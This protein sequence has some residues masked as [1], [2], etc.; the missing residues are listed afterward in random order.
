MAPTLH[1]VHAA[2]ERRSG[3]RWFGIRQLAHHQMHQ[4]KHTAGQRGYGQQLNHAHQW[5][6]N[7]QC[8]QQLDIAA[9]NPSPLVNDYQQQQ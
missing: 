5:E 2:C 8:D 4:R 9:A 1:C 7:R 3:R 6:T